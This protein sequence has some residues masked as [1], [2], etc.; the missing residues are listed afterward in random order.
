MQLG[1]AEGAVGAGDVAEDAAGADRSELLIITNQSDTRPAVDGEP[2]CGV[3]GEGVG[4]AGLVDNDQRRP[5]DP[6]AQSGSLPFRRD[7]CGQRNGPTTEH[8]I[9]QQIHQRRGTVSGQV[10]GAYLSLRFGPD[11]GIEQ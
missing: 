2:D 6:A 8:L 7:Q 9:D 10:D 3:E 4:H 1:Q 11:V 5:A